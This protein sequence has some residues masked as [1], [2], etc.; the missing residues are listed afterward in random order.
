MLTT[1]RLCTRIIRLLHA[2]IRVYDAAGNQ[3]AI[4]V[5]HGEQQDVLS[6]DEE[7]LAMLLEK[8]RREAPILHL[9]AE[10]IV[11]GAVRDGE[12]VYLLGPCCVGRDPV[13][14]ARRL[15]RRHGMDPRKPYRVSGVYLYDFVELLL[16]LHEQLNDGKMES[17]EL[18]LRSF[19]DRRFEQAMQEKVHQ[20]FYTLQESAAVHNPYDQELREQESIRTGDLEALYRSFAE[21]YVGKIG[22]LSHDPL[23]HAKNLAIVLITLA[24]RSAITGG[25]LPEVAFSMSDAF[26]QRVEELNNVGEAVALGKQA[27]V[28]FCT[29]V[30][31]LS[32]SRGHSALT[33]QCKALIVQQLHSRLPVKELARQLEVT[34]DHLSHLFVREEG[35]KLTDYITREK[36][37]AAKKHLAYTDDSYGSLAFSLGFSSQS[38]FGQAF[39]KWA[40]MTP[41]Q[42]RERYGKQSDK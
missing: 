8:G 33:A 17:N 42:Y 15:V 6:C 9:E 4:Y 26:V 28:E 5:D 41:K 27:E 13:A 7:Y 39:K 3:T 1:E 12:T 40:G 32:S 20:V 37:T 38:H 29:A 10:E 34:P 16:T 25:V 36:I 14:A 21:T 24:S 18:L 30:R 23:R 11:Y 31:D 19:C 35:I 22:V 2:P